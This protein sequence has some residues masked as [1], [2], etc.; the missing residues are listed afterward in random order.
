V[1]FV[2]DISLSNICE[3]KRP[4]FIIILIS[5]LSINVLAQDKHL[6]FIGVIHPE[7]ANPITYKLSFNI[8]PEGKLNGTSITD[9]YGADRTVSKIEGFWDA[10]LGTISF[11]EVENLSTKSKAEEASFCYVNLEKVAVRQ[12]GDT[13]VVEGPF[14][15]KFPDGEFCAKGQVRLISAQILERAMT[16]HPDIKEALEEMN[17]PALEV[18]ESIK[19]PRRLPSEA[20]F[21]NGEKVSLDWL[22]DTLKLAVW[23]SFEEDGDRINI[24]V[25]DSLLASN[26]KVLERKQFYLIPIANSPT[27]IRIEATAEGSN[28]PATVHAH[29]L[30]EGDVQ[31]L[32]VKLKKNESVSIEV[33]PYQ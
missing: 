16:E 27:T 32:V 6:E 14:S 19:S 20:K 23:D 21:E 33:W 10:E 29:L 25:N 9:F 31:A 5:L 17:H 7:G 12:K 11:R 3:V 2:Q 1:F 22:S 4:C 24:Y 18:L 30:D 13:T 28:P 15:G 8:N 26:L